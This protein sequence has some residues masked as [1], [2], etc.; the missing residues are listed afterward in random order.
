MENNTFKGSMFGGFK[1]Q[2]VLD[3][4]EKTAKENSEAAEKANS[5]IESLKKELEQAKSDVS[6]LT[7][8]NI[9]VTTARDNIQSKLFDATESLDET[10]AELEKRAAEIEALR[11]KAYE[12]GAKISELE[13][14]VEKYHELRNGIADVELAAK[15]RAADLVSEAKAQADSLMSEAAESA[16]ATRLRAEQ[17]AE[18]MRSQL[19]TM[20]SACQEQYKNLYSEFEVKAAHIGGELCKMS[21]IC[22]Q[23]PATFERL[24]ESL[25]KLTDTFNNKKD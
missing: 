4:I 5:E 15:K 21:Q 8:E 17:R 25:A 6:R 23:F 3:Y 2:D 14:E 12:F 19:E 22:A 11:Q 13:P 20:L 24:G 10:K 9:A 1:R 18:A 16:G 7:E